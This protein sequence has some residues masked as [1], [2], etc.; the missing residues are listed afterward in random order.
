VI[1]DEIGVNRQTRG[2]SKNAA[3]RVR[4]EKPTE[5]VSD[6][7]FDLVG[8]KPV[9]ADSSAEQT[10][11]NAV[12]GTPEVSVSAESI[13]PN[14]AEARTTTADT[15]A[16]TETPV[17]SVAE[18]AAD[19]ET[20]VEAVAEVVADTETPVEAVAEVVADTETPAE[21]VVEV[22]ADTETPAEALADVAVDTETPV[23]AVAEVVAEAETPTEIVAAIELVVETPVEPASQAAPVG[24]NV[25][26]SITES[27]TD[28]A[29]PIRDKGVASLDTVTETQVEVM[30]V[31]A[32][33]PSDLAK[34]PATDQ[35]AAAILTESPSP[36]VGHET[37][38][39]V[40]AEPA[41]AAAATDDVPAADT[42][43]LDEAV[44]GARAANDPREVRR[45]RVAAQKTNQE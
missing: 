35:P 5:I 37:I 38:A 41:S 18:V 3:K 32:P 6:I 30:P 13:A 26:E 43:A 2:D 23:E 12:Q 36:E 39:A 40:K 31:Q 28:V 34:D 21:A 11:T 14:A 44:P 45:R 20:P 1:V 7:D 10:A 24:D 27:A 19:T 29:Q 8:K 33:A 15:E 42:A 9:V 25:T 4:P 16:V 17:E 22:V